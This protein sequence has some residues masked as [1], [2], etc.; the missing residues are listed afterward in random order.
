MSSRGTDYLRS[1]ANAVLDAF[2]KAVED[3]HGDQSVTKAELDAIAAK[4]KQ[5]R[6][7]DEF[8]SRQFHAI[9]KMAREEIME[10]NRTN[11]FGRIVAHPLTDAFDLGVLDRAIMPNFFSFLH[12]VLGDDLETLT[13]ECSEIANDLRTRHPVDFEWDQVY[14]DQRVRVVYWRVLAR[15]AQSFGRFEMRKDWFITLMQNRPTV[16]SIAPNA[17]LPGTHHAPDEIHPF[18][19]G[20]FK[21]M[22]RALFKPV[23]HLSAEDSEWFARLIGKTPDDAFGGFLTNL[24]RMA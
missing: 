17:F 2:V 3:F 4:L 16:V 9:E 15:I 21:V 24:D 10:Q 23:R 18:N 5:D 8:F 7:L 14:A 22:F 6:S 13:R 19:D 11:A 1:T 12:L 20:H